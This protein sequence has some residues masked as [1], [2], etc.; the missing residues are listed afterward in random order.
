MVKHIYRF[1][2]LLGNP[3]RRGNRVMAFLG[4]KL[5]WDLGLRRASENAVLESGPLSDTTSVGWAF[6]RLGVSQKYLGRI[7]KIPGSRDGTR[8]DIAHDQLGRI[9]GTHS[10]LVSEVHPK[11]GLRPER[12]HAG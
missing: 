3:L 11:I 7:P 10:R 8:R 12:S 5:R 4:R 6:T 2:F 1:Q 9:H